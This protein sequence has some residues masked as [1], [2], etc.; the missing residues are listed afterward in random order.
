MASLRR[1]CCCSEGECLCCQ[2][3]PTQA[4]V[5]F[6]DLGIAECVQGYTDHCPSNSAFAR[7][8]AVRVP[9]ISPVYTLDRISKTGTC[10]SGEILIFE[11][12]ISIPTILRNVEIGTNLPTGSPCSTPSISGP[13]R[14]TI[15]RGKTGG[16]ESCS[17]SGNITFD[18]TPVV[19]GCCV[20]PTVD[21]DG[22][23]DL[24]FVDYPCAYEEGG[25]ESP[26]PGL[27]GTGVIHCNNLCY[28]GFVPVS[29]SFL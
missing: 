26:T 3:D 28:S 4:L 24:D 10:A 2:S 29:V 25:V 8:F 21:I 22:A 12:N 6:T 19:A 7:A 20:T 16:E 14:L 17:V 15:V 27:S 13:L 1:K 11:L 9:F 18:G 23:W 5:T